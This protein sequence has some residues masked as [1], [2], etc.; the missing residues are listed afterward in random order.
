MPSP[1]NKT[2][3]LIFAWLK[4]LSVKE[5]L[6]SVSNC[7]FSLSDKIDVA[8]KSLLSSKGLRESIVFESFSILSC[9]QASSAAWLKEG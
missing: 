5:T 7:K 8:K 6:P 3:F 2:L 1:T 4:S 9:E